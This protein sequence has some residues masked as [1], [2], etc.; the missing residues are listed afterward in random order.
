V[1]P[2]LSAVE[3]IRAQIDELF[4][5]GRDLDEALEDAARFSACLLL[6]A[7]LEA[8]VSE[9]LGRERYARGDR[10]RV[11]YP[12]GDAEVTVKTTADPA[13]AGPPRH[14]LAAGLTPRDLGGQV[15]HAATQRP[16]AGL[17]GPSA[18]NGGRAPRTDPL[19]EDHPTATWPEHDES[20][21]PGTFTGLGVS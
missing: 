3:R 6:Q 2:R 11:G 17:P 7:A 8:E 15:P 13:A 14:Y 9:F 19:V 10:D 16:A 20:W 1:P 12:N 5:T 4:A 21:D 18:E